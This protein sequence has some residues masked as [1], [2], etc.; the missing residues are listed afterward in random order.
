MS[1]ANFIRTRTAV[2]TFS[3]S[4][5]NNQISKF[6][7]NHQISVSRADLIIIVIIQDSHKYINNEKECCALLFSSAF[8]DVGL[9]AALVV[10]C[11]Q[12][13]FGCYEWH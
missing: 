9:S 12:Q 11:G 10:F 1:Y 13:I 3:Y 7:I 6:E 2:E 8:P 5:R 4:K